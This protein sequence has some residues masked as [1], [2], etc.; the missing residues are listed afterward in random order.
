MTRKER[1]FQREVTQLRERQSHLLPQTTFKRCVQQTAL[2]MSTSRLR[3]NA[4][5]IDA[6]QEAAEDEIT[7]VFIGANMVAGVA[8]RDTVTVEDM[9][10]Y[11]AIRGI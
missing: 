3:F 10:N 2:D 8:K 4:D 1:R 9:K 5:A 6:L 7:R 11:L